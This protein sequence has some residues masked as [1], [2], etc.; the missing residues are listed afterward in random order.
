MFR[1]FLRA[2]QVMNYSTFLCAQKCA[3]Y[4][5]IHIFINIYIT[6]ILKKKKRKIKSFE[7]SVYGC[8]FRLAG[9]KG[10]SGCQ[11]AFPL[12]QV[13]RVCSGHGKRRWVQGDSQGNKPENKHGISTR[14]AAR[15]STKQPS[16]SRAKTAEAPPQPLP[17]GGNADLLSSQ[18]EG[19]GGTHA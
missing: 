18:W 15:C 19:R 6:Y 10:P 16:Q 12:C 8:L 14:G 7:N 13:T 9:Y 11:A 17:E 1:S 4:I 3:I 5:C 2:N